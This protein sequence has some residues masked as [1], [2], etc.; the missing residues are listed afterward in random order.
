MPTSAA[1]RRSTDTPIRSATDEL[2]HGRA[3]PVVNWVYARLRG[4]WP[5]V[6]EL[7][8][9]PALYSMFRS[10]PRKR[11]SR[12]FFPLALDPRLRGD[13]RDWY[14]FNSIGTCSR[15]FAAPGQL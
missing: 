1:R 13:E 14:R 15:A 10:F 12:S 4:L 2:R 3:Q 11:E 7:F 8:E 9:R 5:G 6:T